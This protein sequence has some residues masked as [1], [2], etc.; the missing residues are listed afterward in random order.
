MK[1]CES[2][3]CDSRNKDSLYVAFYSPRVIVESQGHQEKKEIE[4][5][6]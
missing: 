6:G 1:A 3:W 2:F 4:E 5:I